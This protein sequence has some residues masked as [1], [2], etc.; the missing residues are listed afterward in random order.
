MIRT[1]VVVSDVFHM[2]R[3]EYILYTR[4][5][6]ANKLPP[7]HFTVYIHTQYTHI[8]YTHIYNILYIHAFR[9]HRT[10][11]GIFSIGLRAYSLIKD[12]ESSGAKT[13]LLW[14]SLRD[15]VIDLKSLWNHARAGGRSCA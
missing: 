7:G 5:V 15:R 4:N 3:V 11:Y 1:V 13:S 9:R 14:I 12:L 10:V 2:Y 8:H 6:F